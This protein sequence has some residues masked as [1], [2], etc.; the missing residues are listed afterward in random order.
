MELCRDLYRLLLMN[1][2]GDFLYRESVS[3]IDVAN[4]TTTVDYDYNYVSYSFGA[5]Y[6]LT[7]SQAIFGR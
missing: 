7:D 2:D 5:N 4:P 1:N 3:A 6:K